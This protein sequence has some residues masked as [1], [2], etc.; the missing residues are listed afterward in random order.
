MLCT[1]QRRSH[2]L[3]E[4]CNPSYATRVTS[5]SLLPPGPFPRSGTCVPWRGG[6]MKDV[7]VGLCL[8]ALAA[9]ILYWEWRADKRWMNGR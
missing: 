1:T 8:V 9:C 4:W 7:V 5:R 3:A 6:E 2:V